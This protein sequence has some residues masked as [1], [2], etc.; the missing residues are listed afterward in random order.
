IHFDIIQAEAGANLK[1]LLEIEKRLF[2]STDDLKIQH[3]KSV[4]GSLDAS[5]NLQK[6]FTTIEK[7]KEELADYLCEDRSKLSLEDVFNT[8]KTFRGLFLKALQENQERKE[9]AAKSEK[10]KKQLKEEDAK[11]LKGEYGK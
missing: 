7:K 9:K 10:R 2:L 3:G 6:E 4:Q 5:K 11:R 1:K 8:M